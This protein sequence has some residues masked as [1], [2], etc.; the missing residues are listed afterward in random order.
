MDNCVTILHDL[1]EYKI[2]LNI[3]Y[4]EISQN[5]KWTSLNFVFRKI[6]RDEFHDIPTVLWLLL[7][8]LKDLCNGYSLHIPEK[9][10]HKNITFLRAREWKNAFHIDIN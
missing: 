3:I 4:N 2:S 5:S 6:L 10:I 8:V 7:T 1:Y 9:K